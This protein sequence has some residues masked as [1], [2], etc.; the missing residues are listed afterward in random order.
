MNAYDIPINSFALGSP[1][2]D[3]HYCLHMEDGFWITYFS[4]RGVRSGLCI[5]CNVHDAVNF[6]I[7]FLLKDKLP[8]ISWKSIDLFKNT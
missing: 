1:D 3:E 2:C 4:E 5:F 8:E 7:W 6:F